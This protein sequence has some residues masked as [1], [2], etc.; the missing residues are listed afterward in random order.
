L[1]WFDIEWKSSIE[2]SRA[3]V[4]TPPAAV[5]VG[6]AVAVDVAPAWPRGRGVILMGFDTTP[7]TVTRC[8][9]G[10]SRVIVFCALATRLSNRSSETILTG[11]GVPGRAA[12][13]TMT[14][15]VTAGPARMANVGSGPM[16]WPSIAT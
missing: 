4:V 15:W 6:F 12:E 7:S 13:G 1:A 9:P 3:L 11:N 2:T 5:V 16:R 8:T 14:R 10:A